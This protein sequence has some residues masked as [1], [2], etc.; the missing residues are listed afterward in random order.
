MEKKI[1]I[2]RASKEL[3]LSISFKC[4]ENGHDMKI[5]PRETYKRGTSS[6]TQH[7][8]VERDSE[9]NTEKDASE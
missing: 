3:I 5:M 7:M 1:C 9:I 4:I 6:V 2:F 8:L